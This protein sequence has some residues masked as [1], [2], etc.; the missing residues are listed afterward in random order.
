MPRKG[1]NIYKRKDGRWE[2]RYKSGIRSNGS[3]QYSSVYGKTYT[4]VREKLYKLR[5]S[6]CKNCSVPSFTLKE[7]T[8]EWLES[9]SCRVKKSTFSN[10]K[11]KCQKY[12]I[13]FMG[14][15]KYKSLNSEKIDD[16][17]FFLYDSDKKL[18]GKY[19]SDIISVMKSIAKYAS[20]KYGFDNAMNG[21]APVR[22]TT[23]WDKATLDTEN[24]ASLAKA[25]CSVGDNTDLGVFL[26]LYT[27]IRIGELCALK[28]G[29]IDIEKGII[30]IERT[31]QRIQSFN[32]DTAT[33]L[34]FMTPKSS[35]SVRTIPIP[36]FL[37]HF[38][39][40]RKSDNG[41]FVLS[42][43]SKC[44][45]PRTMQYRFKSLL[46]KA[47]LPS[48]NF[49]ILRHTFATN[50]IALGFDVKTLSEILGHSS[51]QITLNCYVHSSIER[52]RNC[53]ELIKEGF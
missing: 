15:I 51:S 32:G 34:V 12:I 39:K 40:K 30:S 19:I 3:T 11:M 20:R 45:E 7:L 4:E 42:G 17:F 33:Q 6:A 5:N 25:A 37:L 10:Y 50:C 23:T 29:D 28:W 41:F 44:V 2:G 18:S 16:F 24:I 1:E 46:K 43:S 22:Q 47:D 9:I 8:E 53:M 26:C 14:N 21:L 27:G 13:P 52:K 38:L 48:F 36:D 49:H 35:T 31:V